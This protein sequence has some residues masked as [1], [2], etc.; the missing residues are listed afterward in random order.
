MGLQ[1]M[2]KFKTADGEGLRRLITDNLN[3]L[4]NERVK[5]EIL[6]LLQEVLPHG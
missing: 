4:D 1:S 2:Q 5:R 3:N 6:I